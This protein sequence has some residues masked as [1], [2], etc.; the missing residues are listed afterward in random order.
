[1]PDQ[2]P[3][4]KAAL[5]AEAA[6]RLL[7]IP[8][9]ELPAAIN[10]LLQQ[11]IGSFRADTAPIVGND[12]TLTPVFATVIHVGPE[13][14]GQPVKVDDVLA[15]ID[16]YDSLTLADL[17]T[18]YHRS[19]Q[20]KAI[21]KTP[22]VGPGDPA[23][24]V[25]TFFIVL[26]R[27]SALTLDQV[28]DE[29][30]RK[31]ATMPC[32]H[33]PDVVAVATKG[34]VNYS[35]RMPGE[36]RS[37]DFFLP[38]RGYTAS[39]AP[40]LYITRTFRALGDRTFNKIVASLTV[41]LAIY[42][43]SAPLES[44]ETWLIGIPAQGIL[45][46]AYQF[47]LAAELRPVEDRD[48]ISQYLPND[49]FSIVANGKKV[50]GSVRFQHWQDGG[51]I[52]VAGE[53]P[54]EM[55]LIFLRQEVPAIKPQDLGLIRRP[56]IQLSNVL[57]IT[58]QDFLRT[59]QIFQ[60]RSANVRV[61]KDTGTVMLKKLADEGAASPFYARM[62]LGIYRVRQALADQE[63]RDSF[64]KA[65]EP[66]LETLSAARDF[67][68]DLSD[69]WRAHREKIT[70]GAAIEFD[71]NRVAIREN[72]D[73]RLKRDL[74]S[75][76]NTVSRLLKQCMQNLTHQLGTDIGFFFKKDSAFRTG[77]EGLRATDAALADYLVQARTWSDP[78]MRLRNED[79]EH[80]LGISLKVDYAIA[81][82]TVTAGEPQIHGEALTVFIARVMDRITCFVEEV[83][84][85]LLQRA[86][87]AGISVTEVSFGD[88][89]REAPERFCL[90][91]LP[92]GLPPW[93]ILAHV[94][95]FED[96]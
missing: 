23:A 46:Q 84:I 57:P 85:H 68:K 63:T 5:L 59:L 89:T 86:M 83:T 25:M 41:R 34:I 15:V 50:L 35:T 14:A 78:L 17:E 75:F 54:L 11:H 72:I 65:Y 76:V 8:A 93:H 53:F 80:G 91:V 2:S 32:Y 7:D 79:L 70:S 12:G 1:M 95:R 74:E 39:S 18:S 92:G 52:I 55:F 24:K 37:G 87:P 19:A 4:E 88:R 94:A 48:L 43:P 20:L 58:E 21:A 9:S 26:S 45:A 13:P 51:V 22:P 60:A 49:T 6:C 28:S 33:W 61:R 30:G 67:A 82:R 36:T 44:H 62:M 73:R 10:T 90:T 69:I 27:T 56:G 29:M 64:D 77:I 38:V 16:A 47:N 3:E 40:P 31:N 96:I 42:G 81:G 71:G 66:T